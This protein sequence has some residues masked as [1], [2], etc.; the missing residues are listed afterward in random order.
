M[1]TKQK[2]LLK[3][4]AQMGDV[5]LVQ[6]DGKRIKLNDDA[7]ISLASQLDAVLYFMQRMDNGMLKLI[8]EDCYTYQ[9]YDKKTFLK[10]LSNVFDEFLGKGNTYLNVFE[11]K[12]NS[13]ACSNLN[14]KGFSFVGNKTNHYMDLIIQ[15]KESKVS[16]I[17]E[18]Y[19]FQ[20][21]NDTILKKDKIIIDGLN[22]PF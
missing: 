10:K 21:E 1:N 17:Y 5:I 22:L 2:E 16:D 4:L 15:T 18:C 7:E 3:Q 8:L 20:N 14:C 6:E 12:C 11:G 9:D 13:A 19:D